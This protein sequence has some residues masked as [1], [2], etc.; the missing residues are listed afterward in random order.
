MKV[1]KTVLAKLNKCYAIAPLFYEGKRRF[2]VAAEKADPCCLFDQDGAL[3]DTLWTGPGGVMTM[4]QVPGTDGQLLSTAKFYSPD[5]ST[6]AELVVVTPQGGGRWDMRRLTPIPHVHRFDILGRGGVNWLLVCTVKSGQDRPEGDWSYPGKVYA[7]I[8]PED[9]SAFDESH[10]LSL[11][12]V[13][14]G[15][16]RNHGYTRCIHDGVP[17]GLIS[18]DEGVFRMTPP[19]TPE[20]RWQI[21]RLLDAPVSDALLLDLDGDGLEEL[22]TLSPF[23]GERV[24]IWHE[25]GGGYVPVWTLAEDAP[26]SH[27]ICGGIIAGV[28]T[29]VTGHR[30]GKK[31][32]L[33]IRYDRAAGD[34]AVT[35]LDEGRGPANVMHF[36]NDA[37]ADLLIAA[38]RETDEVALYEI[39]EDEPEN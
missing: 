10:P 26:F 32:L 4:V 16:H 39:T 8:L 21:E 9:L 25:S 19:D 31:N 2:V 23:H 38:N 22:C 6:E 17:A 15:L 13:Q 28:P 7:A 30:A 11:H 24:A 14:D 20:G 3:K 34:Y 36:V 27:A 12:V 33:A 1:K 37:G 29:F 5:E 18:A 35:L